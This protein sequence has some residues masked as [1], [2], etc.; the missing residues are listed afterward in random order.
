M[1]H[2]LSMNRWGDE[3]ADEAKEQTR[4]QSHQGQSDSEPSSYQRIVIDLPPEAAK[5]LNQLI[6]QSGDSP[7]TFFRKAFGLY[8]LSKEAVRQGKFVGIADR[9]DSLETEFVGL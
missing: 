6:Q 7:A 1:A 3:M 5:E 4:D 2:F 9:E 8:K